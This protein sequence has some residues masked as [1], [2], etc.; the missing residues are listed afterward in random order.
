MCP[1][2]APTIDIVSAAFTIPG[3]VFLGDGRLCII[4]TEDTIYINMYAA[5]TMSVKR[6]LDDRQLFDRAF[7]LWMLERIKTHWIVFGGDLN[8]TRSNADIAD[9]SRMWRSKIGATGAPER[10][11]LVD[12]RKSCGLVDPYLMMNP[13]RT[14][15]RILCGWTTC[16]SAK[17]WCRS[18]PT[19]PHL[20]LWRRQ[21]P[22]RLVFVS[23]V[24]DAPA[25]VT[26][27]CR[28]VRHPTVHRCS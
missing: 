21:Y 7:N 10:Y 23:A 6:H 22:G 12:L 17:R 26:T 14:I 5:N 18:V 11:A 28:R 1:F 19:H 8:V 9:G 27:P 24:N 4:T 20:Q 16:S 3:D 25:P 2:R 15:P 13:H